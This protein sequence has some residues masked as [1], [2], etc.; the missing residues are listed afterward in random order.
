MPAA[1]AAIAVSRA[2]ASAYAPGVIDPVAKTLP[3]TS[4]SA[5]GEI[6]PIPNFL[7]LYVK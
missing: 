1:G 5:L 6:V 2:V 3:R 7:S 4:S